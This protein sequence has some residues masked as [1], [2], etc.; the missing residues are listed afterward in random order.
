MMTFDIFNLLLIGYVVF[1]AGKLI[2]SAI[3]GKFTRDE[4]I[5]IIRGGAVLFVI[6]LTLFSMKEYTAYSSINLMETLVSHEIAPNIHI[7][8][9]ISGI[10]RKEACLLK[11]EGLFIQDSLVK[12]PN[13]LRQKC[14]LE[15]VCNTGSFPSSSANIDGCLNEAGY[16]KSLIV[17]LFRTEIF[18]IFSLI[19]V[20]E[21][22]FD[23]FGLF[24]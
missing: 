10:T 15:Y 13:E 12:T 20:L 5:S 24:S 4:F 21:I 7:D 11:Q 14:M 1:G 8:Y 18:W 3:D 19:F 6:Y 16:F 2:I 17:S 9:S 23:V 22:F